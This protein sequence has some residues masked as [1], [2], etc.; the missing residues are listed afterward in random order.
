M[1]LIFLLYNIV[2]YYNE[3]IYQ[4]NCNTY[5]IPL[6]DPYKYLKDNSHNFKG[7]EKKDNLSFFKYKIK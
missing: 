7:Y 4:K 1:M 6:I 3:K 5:Y 2:K